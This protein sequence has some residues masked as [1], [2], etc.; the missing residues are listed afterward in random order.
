MTL[1]AVAVVE[2]G[3]GDG[4][5]FAAAAGVGFDTAGVEIASCAAVIFAISNIATAAI[6]LC[7][8]KLFRFQIFG[9]LGLRVSGEA[10]LRT[11]AS[12]QMRT[13]IPAKCLTITPRE[14]A[15]DLR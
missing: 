15:A 9:S 7:F 4:A 8:I 3:D 1:S 10:E 6:K 5:E 12:A 14:N 11:D 13:A 2:V